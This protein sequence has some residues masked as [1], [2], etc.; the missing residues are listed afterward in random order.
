MGCVVTR[1]GEAFEAWRSADQA[2]RTAERSLQ[3]AWDDYACGRGAPPAREL[4]QEVTQLRSVA[5]VRL[6]A[7]IAVVD[8][9][10][11]LHK[12]PAPGGRRND[13]PSSR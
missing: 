10:V 6:T 2:A 3:R 1:A 12:H 4:I 7:A 11:Q 13:R 5:H 8:D 9:E